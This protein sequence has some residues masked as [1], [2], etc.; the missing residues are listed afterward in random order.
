[1]TLLILRINRS[2][3][4]GDLRRHFPPPR[5]RV[6]SFPAL[7]TEQLF[8]ERAGINPRPMTMMVATIRHAGLV[9][10]FARVPRRPVQPIAPHYDCLY[11]TGGGP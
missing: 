11:T 1:M 2:L 8:C 10:Q 6:P 9:D 7:Y 3:L 4:C 5:A